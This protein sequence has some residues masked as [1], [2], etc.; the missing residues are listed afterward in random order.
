M[1]WRSAAVGR[2]SPWLSRVAIIAYRKQGLTRRELARAFRCSE[3][4]IDN[5]LRRSGWR[6]DDLFKFGNLRT[7]MLT[8]TKTDAESQ[9]RHIRGLLNAAM[10]K[11]ELNA[12]LLQ[13]ALS[14]LR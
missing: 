7:T 8:A 3:S 10:A 6:Y 14:Y 13:R 12:P 4:T 5:V 1:R 11:A 2:N 9:M